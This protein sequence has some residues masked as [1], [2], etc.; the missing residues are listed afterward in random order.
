[1]TKLDRDGPLVRGIQHNNMIFRGEPINQELYMHKLTSFLLADGYPQYAHA[2]PLW[3]SRTLLNY[4]S[5]SEALSAW[6]SCRC[7]ISPCHY[8]SSHISIKLI[9]RRMQQ[10]CY[11]QWSMHNKPTKWRTVGIQNVHSVSMYKKTIL[12]L[13]SGSTINK[14]RANK[15]WVTG[16]KMLKVGMFNRQAVAN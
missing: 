9:V 7:N 14:L 13:R 6:C 5:R 4:G 1:M 2:C 11:I 16:D 8:A 15:A 3:G 10:N 12:S